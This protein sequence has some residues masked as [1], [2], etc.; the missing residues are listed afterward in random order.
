MRSSPI[1]TSGGKRE[2]PVGLRKWNQDDNMFVLDHKVLSSFSYEYL[3]WSGR[4]HSNVSKKYWYLRNATGVIPRVSY[5]G[6]LPPSCWYLKH[7]PKAAETKKKKHKNILLGSSLEILHLHQKLPPRT[8]TEGERIKNQIRTYQFKF[9]FFGCAPRDKNF[10]G[11]RSVFI[12]KA[13]EHVL[14]YFFMV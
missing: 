6:C 10:F 11:S 1:V 3:D 5:I 4:R 8:N 13:G 2:N 9:W 14:D 7:C 12:P